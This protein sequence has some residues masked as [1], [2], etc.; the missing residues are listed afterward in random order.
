MHGKTIW[1]PAV[2]RQSE[3]SDVGVDFPDFPGCISCGADI[4][5]AMHMAAEALDLHTEDLK[6]L[7]NPTPIRDVKDEEELIAVALVP[8]RA[9]R[10]AA[11]KSVR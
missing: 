11:Q 6:T 8:L 10:S 9:R 5:E 4:K 2:L 7:P 3:G 1:Y